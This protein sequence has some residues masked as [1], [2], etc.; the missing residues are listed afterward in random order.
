MTE[1]IDQ[2]GFPKGVINYL[3]CN[4]AKGDYLIKHPLI[5]AVSSVGSTPIA[6][7]IYKTASNAGKRA[8]CHGGANNFLVVTSIEERK[9]VVFSG[10]VKSVPLFS[11]VLP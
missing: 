5:K 10:S 1:Y 6:T 2:A 4:A 7:H 9:R 3:H 8:Q 11:K